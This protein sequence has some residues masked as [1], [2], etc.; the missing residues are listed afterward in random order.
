M[1]SAMSK[2]LLFYELVTPISNTRHAKWS[3]R[4]D[5]RYK[6]AAE[7]NAVPL[8][9]V[10]FIAAAHEFPI[11]FSTADNVLPVAV[12]GLDAD[13]SLFVANDGS[14]GSSYIP[15]FVRRYP[16]VF[17]ASEDGKTLTLCIDESFEGLDRKG[18]SGQRL[19]DDAGVR[20]PYLESMLQF[21][22]AFQGEHQRTRQFG[23]ILKD[24]DVLE[25]SE[26]K[27][28]LPDGTSRSLTGFQCVSRAKLKELNPDKLA[29]MLSNGALELIYLHLYSMR[30]FD[31]LVRKLTVPQPEPAARRE[32]PTQSLT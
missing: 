30:N 3:V 15:A 10:E 12:I 4:A 18:K 1:E 24:L 5:A 7:S 8:M 23:E 32:T 2:Q 13:K 17:S 22:N 27:I 31:D 16:F 9:T 26:A 19:F 25:P 28:T 14:W 6:F 29:G 20:T 21:A 11:V